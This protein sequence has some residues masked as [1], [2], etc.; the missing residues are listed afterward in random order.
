MIGQRL[1]NLSNPPHAKIQKKMVFC[2][3]DQD[4]VEDTDHS[5][6]DEDKIDSTEDEGN[7]DDTRGTGGKRK[8]KYI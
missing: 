8:K 4:E 7:D 6:Q 5:S 3:G 2:E 1:S